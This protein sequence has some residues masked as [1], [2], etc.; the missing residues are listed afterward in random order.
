MSKKLLLI[1]IAIAAAILLLLVGLSGATPEE[2]KKIDITGA[3]Q[4]IEPTVDEAAPSEGESKEGEDSS[5][6][7]QSDCSTNPALP[8]CPVGRK[9]QEQQKRQLLQQ[10][11]QQLE[12]LKK[13]RPQLLKGLQS[14]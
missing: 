11:K 14:P 7:N 5:G 3:E 1:G 13:Y 8:Y 9:I 12:T 6:S 10:T 4:E 2:E